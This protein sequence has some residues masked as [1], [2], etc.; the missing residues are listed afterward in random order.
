MVPSRKPI[1]HTPLGIKSSLSGLKRVPRPLLQQHN[2]GSHRQHNS[3]CLYQQGSGNEIGLPVCPTVE[4]PVLVLQ[5]TLR[6]C[7]I[8]GWLNVIADKL[9]RFGQTIQ[10]VVPSFRSVPNYMLDIYMLKWIFLPPDSTT[11]YSLCHRFQTHRHGQCMHSV[12]S[13]RIWTHMP[14]HQQPFGQSSGE[15]AGLPMQQNHSD[16]TRLAQHALVLGSSGNVQSDPTVPA[17]PSQPCVSAIQPDPAQELVQLESA[18]L[19]PRATT[20]KEQGFSWAVAARIKA[21]QRG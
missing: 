4:N 17:Q 8:P 18:C 13:G 14:S 7:H 1:A 3:A 2:T 19:A 9:S 12:C 21:P 16:C 11:N 10:R 20:I 5:V 15:V 6:A